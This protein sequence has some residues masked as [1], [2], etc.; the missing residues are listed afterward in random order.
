LVLW[1]SLAV[2]AIGIAAGLGGAM[3]ASRSLSGMLYGIG[4]LDPL[5]F[6]GVAGAFGFV[7]TLAAIIPVLRATRVD[8][9]VALRC[10]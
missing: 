4:A 10:D 9:L 1:D 5:T 7:A 3:A 6:A 2:A 8:P